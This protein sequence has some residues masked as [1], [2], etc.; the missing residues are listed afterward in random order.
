MDYRLV[1]SIKMH[2]SCISNIFIKRN[3]KVTAIKNDANRFL[4]LPSI[5]HN[6][7]DEFIKKKVSLKT[8]RNTN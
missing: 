8:C 5:H 3:L 6:K 2:I 1:L 7:F 4:F